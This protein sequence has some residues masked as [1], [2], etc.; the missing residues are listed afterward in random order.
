MYI[1]DRQLSDFQDRKK[2]PINLWS[3]EHD[4]VTRVGGEGGQRLGQV[5]TTSTMPRTSSGSSIQ[6]M[7]DQMILRTALAQGVRDVNELTNRVFFGRHRE[8]G[9]RKLVRGEPQ[10]ESLSREWVDIRD[11]LVRPALAQVTTMPRPSTQ[12]LKYGVPGG[13]LLSPFREER[14]L[15]GKQIYHGGIDVSSSKVP[16][17]GADDP[18][19][20]LPLYATVKRS[21]DIKALNSADVMPNMEVLR[22][23]LGIPGQGQ[24]TLLNALVR[25]QPWK[26]VGGFDYG[27]VLGLACRFTYTKNNGSSGLFTL[28]IQYLHL[29][30]REYLPKD[31]SGKII[32]LAEWAAAGKEKHMGFGP[33]MRDYALLSADKLV[34]GPP[35]LVGFLGATQW[36]HVHIQA[37]Y[38]DGEGYAAFP[39]IDPTVM[40]D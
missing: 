31:G 7:P 3:A 2:H 4:S 28:Y 13:K 12:A 8:R 1:Y 18:R 32:S 21:I 33:E 30:T 11:R 40:I 27:G 14:K 16:G 39:R 22:T 6:N 25:V 29:I 15:K 10:F 34:G 35:L 36:P 19:R 26:P 20:G 9:R 37:S 24:V 38:K 5:P 17:G 23:G